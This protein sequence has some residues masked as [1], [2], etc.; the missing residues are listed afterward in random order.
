MNCTFV[1]DCHNTLINSNFAWI[2]AFVEHIGEDKRKEVEKCLYG[3]K[4]RRDIAKKY[5]ID[6]TLIEE[7]ANKY[8]HPLT[9]TIDFIKYLN[10]INSNVYVISNAPSRRVLRD[11][12]ITGIR[13]HFEYVYTEEDGGKGN[14]KLFDEILKKENAN[15]IVFVGNEEFDDH[16]NHPQVLSMILTDFLRERFKFING[17]QMDENGVIK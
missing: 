12:E 9:K 4:K 16:I 14:L 1:F 6:F 3:K 7:S 11:M 10:S 13:K 15:I 2:E 17:I 8:M 5:S